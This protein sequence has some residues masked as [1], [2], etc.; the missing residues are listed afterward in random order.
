MMADAQ[1][2]PYVAFESLAAAQAVSDGVVVLEGDYGG[3]IYMVVP[4]R[5]VQCGEAELQALL[6]ELDAH[7]WRDP[8][9]A[10]VYYEQ[11]PLGAGIGGGMGGGQV[12]DGVWVHPELRHFEATATAVVRGEPAA[13]KAAAQQGLGAAGRSRRLE[14]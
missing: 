5:H 3:Q 10:R 8:A 14:K 1:G 2:K 11:R 13:P 9:G 4:A 6:S 7:A 12:I